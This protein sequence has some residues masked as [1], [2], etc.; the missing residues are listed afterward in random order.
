[1]HAAPFF[2]N[3]VDKRLKPAYV[4]LAMTHRPN[5]KFRNVDEMR[6]ALNRAHRVRTPGR[7]FRRQ[8]FRTVHAYGPGLLGQL[9]RLR[10]GAHRRFPGLMASLPDLGGACLLFVG[11][12]ALSFLF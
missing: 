4:C 6:R 12:A 2:H 1:M 8:G 5:I 11:I 7:P 9:S 10:H 3:N